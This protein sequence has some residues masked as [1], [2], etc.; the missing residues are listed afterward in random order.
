MRIINVVGARPNFMKIS[1]VMAAMKNNPDFDPVLI[2]TGQHY[3]NNMS[4]QFFKELNIPPADINLNIGSDSQA[5]QVARIIDKF[6]DVCKDIRPDAVLVVGDVNSTMACSIVASKAGIKLIHLEAGLRSYDRSMPEEINRLVTDT[7]ADLLLTPSKDADKNLLKE[8]ISPDKIVCVGN[9]MIDTLY[10]FLP[11]SEKSTIIEKHRLKE[12]EYILLT[13]HRPSNVDNKEQLK[14]LLDAFSVIQK[15][16][17]IIFPVHPRTLK[18]IH[19]FGLMKLI[20]SMPWLIIENTLGYLDFQRLMSCSRLVITDSGGIQEETTVLKIPCIT[21][22]E[23]TER[24]I[25]ITMGSNVLV[26]K[27]TDK[28]LRCVMNVLQ[29]KWKKGKI[30]EQWDGKTAQRVITAIYHKFLFIRE[31]L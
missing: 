27:D 12:K 31:N 30:P 11:L 15:Q 10:Q 29:G 20:K 24:P 5:K 6:E 14:K 19:S 13:L 22:R 7:L 26:G 16:I 3:D 28:L 9:I 25:T 18:N 23:N 8:G 21:L 2:H 1:P 17:P 4:D